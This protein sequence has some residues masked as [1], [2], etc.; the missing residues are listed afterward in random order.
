MTI[1]INHSASSLNQLYAAYCMNV[2]D[3]EMEHHHVSLAEI[4]RERITLQDRSAKMAHFGFPGRMELSLAARNIC[5]WQWSVRKW[6]ASSIH[7]NL[8]EH[9]T[10]E[11]EPPLFAISTEDIFVGCDGLIA[12]ELFGSGVS[13]SEDRRRWGVPSHGGSHSRRRTIWSIG[14]VRISFQGWGRSIVI[15]SGNPAND[16]NGAPSGH[17]RVYQWDGSTFYQ[18]GEEDIDGE[19][20]GHFHYA[21]QKQDIIAAIGLVQ[22]SN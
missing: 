3:E 11:P 5:L 1:A 19:A 12:V 2:D 13:L 8:M 15:A 6:F 20:A 7:K 21:F 9:G 10:K 18:L 17:V 4:R 22:Q 16:G 14:L